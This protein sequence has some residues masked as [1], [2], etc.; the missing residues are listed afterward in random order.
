MTKQSDSR[1]WGG[2]FTEQTDAFVEAF[3]ASVEFDQR[4]A[5]VDIQGSQAH[6]KMLNK[7]GVLTEEEL[8]SIE[9]GLSS[10]KNE[11]ESGRFEW[12]VQLEDV[13][14]NIEA[15]LTQLIGVAGKKLHTGRS[16]NDQIATDIRL[17]LRD[18]IKVCQ[19][20][21]RQFQHGLLDLASKH[22]DTIMPGFTHL[23][24]AQPITFGHHLLA[25]FEM[26]ERDFG[27]LAGCAKRMNI[28][29]LGSAALA[30]TSYPL[31][32]QYTADLL[33]FSAPSRNSLDAVSDRD[34]AIE[35]CADA[36]ICMTHLSR[37]SEEM[38]IW[39]SAQFNFIVL[40]DRY[41]TGSSIMPQKKNPDVPELV[42]GKSGRVFGHLMSLLTLMKSQTL[43]YNKDNQEDKEPLFDTL[44]TLQGSL[45]AFA[46]MV[47]NLQVKKGSMY[48]AAKQGFATATDL[49][50]Y[51]VNKGLPFRDSHEVV[52]IAVA[53]AI[54]KGKDLSECSLKEL[55]TFHDSIEQDVF[56][57][58]TLEGS[59]NLR[60]ITG[61]TAPEQVRFQIEQCRKLIS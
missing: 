55:K 50:D 33:D 8:T 28:L 23:Q 18:E 54:D 3:T 39:S 9:K 46:D 15:R 35:F 26:L 41:C 13:H 22:A 31:D 2:R 58:L 59:V 49:A 14:M 12:S 1:M 61:G 47:P 25:W 37:M 20:F 4:L 48:K 21:I 40:P 6:A 17:Y 36:A 19:Q 10:I 44:D 52:G 29:P 27:R 56:E 34:F 7:I 11:V 43:A 30:G 5:M 38:V 53:Y 24:V 45:R 32:R 16:R 60:N 51:L 57:V 42:R